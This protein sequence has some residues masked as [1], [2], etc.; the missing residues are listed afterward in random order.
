MTV[1]AYQQP[2]LAQANGHPVPAAYGLN[3]IRLGIHGW[4]KAGKSSIGNT[5]PRPVC[6]LDSEQGAQW[7]PPGPR[8][9]WDPARMTV[10]AWDGIWET[11]V[12]PVYDHEVPFRVLE[13]LRTGRHPFNSVTLD[14]TSNLQQR[15][16]MG[17]RGL[18]QFQLQDWGQL[19]RIVNQMITGYG[20]LVSNPVRKVWAVTFIAGTKFDH[21]TGR[22]RMMLQGQSQDYVPYVPEIEGWVYTAGPGDHHMYIAS[23]REFEAG[24]R[25][26]GRL[27]DD[28]KLG[29]PGLVP[30][31]TITDMVTQALGLQPEMRR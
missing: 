23:D 25:L 21:Q 20:D 27:P 8:I 24:N 18:K 26:W 30:G 1:A 5:G 4:Q 9:T 31:W 15:T 22:W 17:M 13:I 19:L 6:Y 16:M 7:L 2:Q 28:M 11:C 3:G 10:P 14:S 12:V 29:Y